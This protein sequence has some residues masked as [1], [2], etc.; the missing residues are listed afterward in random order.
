MTSPFP[1][2]QNP[3]GVPGGAPG[4]SRRGP[5]GLPTP[6]KGWPVGSYPTYAEAQKAVDYLSDNQFP[7]A[8]QV[9]I[10]GVDLMQVERVTGRLSWGKVLAGG[11]LSGAWLGV[12]IGLLLG[13]LTGDL[14]KSMIAAVP[15][16]IMFGLITSSI[17][18]AMSKGTRDFSSTMQLVAGRYDVLCDPQSAERARDMLSRLT[19]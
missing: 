10:V 14:G 17:P 5:L 19:I 11:V 13:I 12:F 3:G 6:P 7:V 18:Y 4:S 8:N 16:G 9:T 1:P 15:A 2:A